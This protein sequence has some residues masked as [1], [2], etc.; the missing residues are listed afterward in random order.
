MVPCRAN[1]ATCSPGG[2]GVF[3]PPSRVRITDWATSGIVSS[4]PIRAATA[5]KLE[6]PGTISVTRPSSA[7]RSSCSW[8]APHS[9]GSPECTRATR[10]PPAAA[11]S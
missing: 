11:R 5:V 3:P 9:A 10:R 6:T 4:R 8:I 2:I 7:H 1:P